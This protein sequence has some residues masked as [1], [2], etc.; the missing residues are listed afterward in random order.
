MAEA[1]KFENEDE[2][3]NTVQYHSSKARSSC[4]TRQVKKQRIDTAGVVASSDSDDE[5]FE[6]S[7]ESGPGSN[8]K[9]YEDVLPLNAEVF[10]HPKYSDFYTL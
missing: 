3:G 6:A 4:K 8:S 2:D 7:V 9:S 1:I 10:L 5:D